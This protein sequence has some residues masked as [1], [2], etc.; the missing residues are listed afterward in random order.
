[1]QAQL[2][3]KCRQCLKKITVI[4]VDTADMPDELQQK[5]NS[6]ILAHRQYCGYYKHEFKLARQRQA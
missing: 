1:M 5:V 4:F 3:I 6:A 2:D